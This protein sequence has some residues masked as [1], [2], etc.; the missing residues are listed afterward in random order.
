MNRYN[1]SLCCG[2][3]LCDLRILTVIAGFVY[4]IL[5]L[6]VNVHLYIV[7]VVFI[8]IQLHYCVQYSNMQPTKSQNRLL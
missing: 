6:T 2:T 3:F 1:L 8:V 5:F 7:T 4:F